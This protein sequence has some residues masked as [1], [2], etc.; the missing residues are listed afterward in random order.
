MKNQTLRK[1]LRE[2]IL[3]NPFA[4][5]KLSKVHKGITLGCTKNLNRRIGIEIECYGSLTVF[6]N[7]ANLGVNKNE[8]ISEI[9]NKFLTKY[10]N[11][12]E[13]NIDYGYSTWEFLDGFWQIHKYKELIQKRINELREKPCK[14]TFKY[15]QMI[16][17]RI[18]I[19]NYTQLPGL[20]LFLKDLKQYCFLNRNGGI[21]IHVDISDILQLCKN[22]IYKITTIANNVIKRDDIFKIFY[23]E[24]ETYK[25]ES[26]NTIEEFGVGKDFWVNCRKSPST[27]EFRIGRQTFSYEI[28]VKQIDQR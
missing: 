21:H 14:S 12:K 9:D 3:R 27:F 1:R 23:K 18:S 10:Y 6:G 15:E 16:E 17:H 7:V 11:V 22:D 26:Y 24:N 25:G 19:S 28:L 20:Y 2:A 4:I 5:D 13:I 8:Q